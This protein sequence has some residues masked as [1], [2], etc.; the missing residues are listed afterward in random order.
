MLKNSSGSRPKIVLIACGSFSPPTPMHFRM[1]EIA[2]D[3]FKIHQSHEVI[4]GIVSPTHDSYGKKG[5]VNGKHRL[6]MLSLG[7]RSSNWIKLS[8]WE[9]NQCHWNRTKVV[10]EYHQNALNNFINSRNIDDECVENEHLWFPHKSLLQKDLIKIKLLCGAD[11]L[12]SFAIPGLW[13]EED[14]EDILINHGIVVITRSGSNPETII[15]ESD[16]LS[17]YRKHIVLITNFVPNDVSS[18]KVR[19]LL[20]RGESVKYLLDDS[21]IQYI[22][23][24]GL[25]NSTTSESMDESDN[26][27]Q[28]TPSPSL[29][30]KS[31]FARVISQTNSN[32]FC[33]GQSGQPMKTPGKAIKL[34]IDDVKEV[35]TKKIK[36]HK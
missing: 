3:Y 11:L 34:C 22:E 19:T 27:S 7:L 5:L 9:I 35:S 20:R 26:N 4:G 16:I 12:E 15:F 10:L 30:D 25:Y 13:K 32:V 6:T 24:W 1:F 17:K 14:I 2:K 23:K 18:T 31:T 33:C 29:K 21:V 8:D 28:L 36:M